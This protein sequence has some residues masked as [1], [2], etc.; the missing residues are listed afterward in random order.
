MATS[1]QVA[2]A[3]Q[4]QLE[5]GWRRLGLRLP[6]EAAEAL[7][8]LEARTGELPTD[9]ISRLLLDAAKRG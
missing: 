7:R 2:K 9:L 5:A 8:K 1:D 6:P 3:H 4:R